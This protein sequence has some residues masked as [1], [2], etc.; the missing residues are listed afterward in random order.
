MQG[1]CQLASSCLDRYNLCME[2]IEHFKEWLGTGSI[3]IFGI[4]FSGKDTVGRHLAELLDSE[5]ISSGDIMREIFSNPSKAAD[6]KLWQAAKVG[7]LSGLLMSTDEFRQMINE[8]LKEPDLEGKSLILS[9]IGRWSGEEGPV[10]SALQEN[11]HPTKAVLLLNISEQELWKRWQIAQATRNGGRDDDDSEE[12]V[13]RRI[14]EFKE[15]TLP[16]IQTY[17]D[18]GILLEINGEQPREQVL[19]DVIDTLYEFSRA[20]TS[21]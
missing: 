16:V 20:S 5:F 12:K 8:R 18:M 19:S 7:S 6:E 14:S 15:K 4:Q 10:M 13:A 21:Q 3:N 11:G 1:E 9:T 17:R 2:N